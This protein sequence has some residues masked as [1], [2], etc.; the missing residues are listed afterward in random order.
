MF[1]IRRYVVYFVL[2]AAIILILR[3]LLIEQPSSIG[4]S[5][6]TQYSDSDIPPKE[7]AIPLKRFKWTALK[8]HY[9]IPASSLFQLPSGKPLNLPKIQHDFGPETVEHATTRKTRQDAVKKTFLRCWNAYRTHAWMHDELSP[10]SGE[11]NDKFGGWGA[12][13]VDNLDTLWIMGLKSDF[14]EAA[15]AVLKID[16]SA[17][18]IESVNVFETNIRHL[19]GLLAAYD[20]SGNKKLLN[21]AR[22]FGEM[23]IKPFDT[24]NHLPITRWDWEQ[25]ARN[26]PQRGPQKILLA[27]I[28]SLSMEFTRLSQLTGDPKWFSAVHNISLLFAA[29]LKNTLLPGMFPVT[30]GA[31][32]KLDVTKDNWFTLN[33]MAD[34]FFEY[35]PKMHLLLGGLEP[36]YHKLYAVT[37]STAIKHTLYRP[38]TPEN[39]D[40]LFSGAARVKDASAELTALVQHLGCFTGGMF[41]LGGRLFDPSHF[42][43]GKKLT[44]GCIWAY[45]SSPLGVMTEEFAVVACK[46]K[47]SCK[48]NEQLWRDDIQKRLDA[49]V[50]IDEHIA[51]HRLQNGITEYTDTK[52]HLRPEAIESVFLLYRMTGDASLQET[53]WEMYTSIMDI[54]TTKLA[55]AALLDVTHLPN[56]LKGGIESQ[57]FDSMES[58]WLA[59][60]LK[61]FY[62]IFSEPDLIS[63]DE[64]VFNT[65][66]HPFRRPTG[67]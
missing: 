46:D 14:E 27:E 18:K 8:T 17:I 51:A 45:K 16:T 67:R 35:L 66:A 37:M 25:A 3:K 43:I 29:E 19:G 12:T 6:R 24:P 65:E 21:K 40:I 56:E 31:K 11:V 57:Q 4:G 28:G 30:I 38:M 62:L 15:K 1:S 34:S 20:L 26:A 64:Y 13:L 23:L 5:G 63:L 22:E 50:D 49:G 9:P 53:A 58:F 55:N 39:A 33:G 48:W 7:A 2:S 47:D 42:D 41:Q 59:E 10:L 44:N 54:S 36:I 32:D 52:Y 61:Y 60:T